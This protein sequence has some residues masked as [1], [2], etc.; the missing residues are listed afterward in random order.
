[1][2]DM[3]AIDQKSVTQD[4]LLALE[5]NAQDDVYFEVVDGEIVEEKRGMTWQHEDVLE[6][7]YDLL[8]AYAIEHQLGKIYFAGRRYRLQGTTGAIRRARV[9]D[10]SFLR[11]A[12]VAIDLEPNGD[13]PGAPDLAVEVASPGQ[14]SSKLF[15]KL[16]E[17]LDAGSEEAWLINY[18]RKLLHR[19]RGDI[20][21]Y[22]VYKLGDAFET[23]LFPGLVIQVSDMFPP[24]G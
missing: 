7:L 2:A 5:A 1:M 21:G 19:L 8:R 22:E 20:D 13:Y 17:Y 16:T 14:S 6:L 10:L 9:P 12:R 18:R 4:M 24:Q 23:P 3:D 15:N 11:V